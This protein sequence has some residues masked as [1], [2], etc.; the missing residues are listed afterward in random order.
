MRVLCVISVEKG[1]SL[2]LVPSGQPIPDQI[3]DLRHVH[4][5]DVVDVTVYLSL[6]DDVR[7]D[8]FVAH[9]FWE[10]FVVSAR[11]IDL[12][13]NLGGREAVVALGVRGVHSFAFQLSLLEPVVEGDVCGIGDEFLVEAVHAFC[14]WTVLTQHLGD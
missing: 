2:L 5:L 1:H 10:R 4:K 6:D 8:A 3:L 13:S 7:R 9:G 14:V 12:V 11:F